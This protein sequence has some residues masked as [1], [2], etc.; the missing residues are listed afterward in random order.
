MPYRLISVFAIVIASAML[1]TSI[2]SAQETPISS[3]SPG[4]ELEQP[5]RILDATTQSDFSLDPLPSS[6][7]KASPP[8]NQPD[9][10]I[11]ESRHRLDALEQPVLQLAEQV[12]AMETK[13]GKNHAESIKLRSELR[14]LVQ[15]TFAARQEIQRT[16]LAEFNRRLQKMQQTIDA[17][18]QIVD[19]IV[20][21]RV[22]ELLDPNLNWTHSEDERS[23]LAAT[24]LSAQEVRPPEPVDVNQ[25]AQDTQKVTLQMFEVS[26]PDFMK[27]REVNAEPFAAPADLDEQLRKMKDSKTARHFGP[28]TIETALDRTAGFQLNGTFIAPSGVPGESPRDIEFD[29]RIT[30][31]PHIHRGNKVFECMWNLRLLD[32]FNTVGTIPGVNEKQVRIKVKSPL[33]GGPGYLCGP[34]AVANSSDRRFIH[35]LLDGT[36]DATTASAE[37]SEHS[38]DLLGSLQG[39]W[40]CEVFNVEGETLSDPDAVPPI[41]R[42]E[43]AVATV[44]LKIRGVDEDY[45]SSKEPEEREVRTVWLL[46]LVGSGTPQQVNL[47]VDPNGEKRQQYG[48]IEC[49]EDRLRICVGAEDAPSELNRPAIFAPGSKVIYL[50]ARRPTSQPAAPPEGEEQLGGNT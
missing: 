38:R 20:D 14:D 44:E 31:R 3:A 50:E 21:R 46:E 43:G 34:F 6:A 23:P 28:H 7:G 5:S 40:K 1:M 13:Q 18:E 30:I 17:R 47:L 12:R 16:E 26:D 11:T 48:I 19:R 45:P 4:I 2:T 25:I 41:V 15:K 22:E 36:T 39:E 33:P 8:S 49:T 27:D 32:H 35:F 9:T 24:R 10:T 42:I 29:T 37:H